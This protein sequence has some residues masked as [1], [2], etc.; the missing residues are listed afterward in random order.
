[1]EFQRMSNIQFIKNRPSFLDWLHKIESFLLPA[2]VSVFIASLFPAN[3]VAASEKTCLKGQDQYHCFSSPNLTWAYKNQ[4]EVSIDNMN[5]GPGFNPELT[6]TELASGIVY[7]QYFFHKF[8]SPGSA[9]FLCGKTNS[10][11]QLL[12]K[13]GEVVDGAKFVSTKEMKFKIEVNENLISVDEGYL[14]DKD[15]RPLLRHKKNG[16]Q[17]LIEADVLKVK[18][19]VDFDQEKESRIK[20]NQIQIDNLDGSTVTLQNAFESPKDISNPRWNEVFTE[21]A[22][23]RIFWALGIPADRM[24]PMK[25]LVCYGCNSHPKNQTDINLKL[26]SLFNTVS[27]EKKIRGAK[28]DEGFDINAVI[29]KYYDSWTDETKLAFELLAL[30][31]RLIGF[32]NAISLQ[33]RLQCEP[34]SFHP[35]TGL[36]DAPVAMI[37]DTGSSF[38]GVISTLSKLEF[39]GANPRGHLKSYSKEKVFKGNAGCVL[40]RPFGSDQKASG[41]RLAS[42]HQ[43]AVD[44]MSKRLNKFDPEFV[45]QIFSLAQFGDMEPQ[46]RGPLDSKNLDQKRNEIIEKWVQAFMKRVDEIRN[47]KCTE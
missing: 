38:A 39:G 44:E 21:V 5:K 3:S 27:L 23:T 46:L 1:M 6:A 47:A 34:G 7:C 33:N 28:L 25:R 22:A 12:N 16:E 37:Q 32:E 42:V 35:E 4:P 30:A 10:M 40:F 11:G 31:S 9:K 43:A 8:S 29:E 45:R 14:L 41:K 20:R 18:Y 13:K 2:L 17:E 15:R 26:T 19:F 24:Y 36:C